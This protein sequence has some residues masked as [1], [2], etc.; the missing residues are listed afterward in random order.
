ML[1]YLTDDQAALLHYWLAKNPNISYIALKDLMLARWGFTITSQAVSFH[2][3]KY[4][5]VITNM[6]QGETQWQQ[7]KDINRIRKQIQRANR[8]GPVGAA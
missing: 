6:R 7:Q 8:S 4:A 5:D 2:K 1:R 3:R